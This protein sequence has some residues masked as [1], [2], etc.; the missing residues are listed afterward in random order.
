MVR[1]YH[2]LIDTLNFVAALI[3]VAIMALMVT[4]IFLRA[5]FRMPLHGVPEI[6]KMAVVAIAWWQIPYALKNRNHLRSTLLLNLLP[7]IGQNV[8]NTANAVCGCV[9]MALIAWFA[10]PEMMRAWNTGAFE[11]EHPVRIPTWPIWSVIVIGSALTAIEYLIQ[12]GQSVRGRYG[13][14]TTTPTE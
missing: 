5:G 6:V 14:D 7:P 13:E 3:I 2:R 10:Y 9:L 11:G 4:D 1:I 12:A 8:I